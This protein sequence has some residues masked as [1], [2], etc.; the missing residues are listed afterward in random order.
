[1]DKVLFLE[2]PMIEKLYGGHKIQDRFEIGDPNK[3]IGEYWVISAHD[4]GLSVITNGIYQSQTLK[5]V[6]ANHRE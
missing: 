3:K 1:M 5:D 4:H 6:Y 2:S